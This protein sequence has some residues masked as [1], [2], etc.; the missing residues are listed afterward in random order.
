MSC[1]DPQD[2]LV[3]YGEYLH[4]NPY[5]DR[6]V[7]LSESLLGELSSVLVFQNTSLHRGFLQMLTGECNFARSNGLSVLVFLFGHGHE[8]T[9]GVFLG[10][11]DSKLTISDFLDA[12]GDN[13]AVTVVSTACFSG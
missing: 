4:G 2:L 13:I 7:V 10:T 9:H 12:I 5:C 11:S 1:A 3:E 8:S 6:K